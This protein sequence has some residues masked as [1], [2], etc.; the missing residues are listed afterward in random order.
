MGQPLNRHHPKKHSPTFMFTTKKLQGIAR[1]TPAE[2]AA[3][4]KAIAAYLERKGKQ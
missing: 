4:D 1:D 3:K 2:R